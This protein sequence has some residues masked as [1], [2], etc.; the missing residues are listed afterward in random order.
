MEATA[1]RTTCAAS[2]CGE[3]VPSK[4]TLTACPTLSATPHSARRPLA[5]MSTSVALKPG[6]EIRRPLID[7]TADAGRRGAAECSSL[8]GGSGRTPAGVVTSTGTDAVIPPGARGGDSRHLRIL[9]RRRWYFG[10]LPQRLRVGLVA[11]LWRRT[12][13]PVHEADHK[14]I[15]LRVENVVLGLVVSRHGLHVRYRLR[16]PDRR[17]R[18]APGKRRLAALLEKVT[19]EC[20]ICVVEKFRQGIGDRLRPGDLLIAE[21]PIV[22]RLYHRLVDRLDSRALELV[23]LGFDG[24]VQALS[25]FEHGLYRGKRQRQSAL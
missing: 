20:V 2:D 25:V 16:G 10:K 21:A 9:R 7:G 19:D 8:C 13:S 6:G 18:V 1:L 5:E 12:G 11:R 23:V 17:I 22:G 15:V 24:L 4:S 14:C 3:N